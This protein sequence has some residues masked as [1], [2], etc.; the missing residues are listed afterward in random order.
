MYIYLVKGN[1]IVPPLYQLYI[2]ACMGSLFW[3]FPCCGTNKG[4][5]YLILFY[6]GRATGIQS[7]IMVYLFYFIY[8]I[9]N[10]NA[11]I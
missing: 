5:S 10:I 2:R 3:M 7:S 11:T 4:I 9:L 8:I 6:C 1:K